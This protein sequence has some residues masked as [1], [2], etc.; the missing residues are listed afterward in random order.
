MVILYSLWRVWRVFIFFNIWAQYIL[1]WIDW[2]HSMRRRHKQRKSR[3]GGMK[4]SRT[5]RERLIER[6]RQNP[7]ESIDL[8]TVNEL[9]KE[10]VVRV[11]STDTTYSFVFEVTPKVVPLMD[12]RKLSREHA[13]DTESNDDMGVSVTKLCAKISFIR[14]TP[15]NKVLDIEYLDLRCVSPEE[16]QTEIV[17]QKKIHDL[18]A[19]RNSNAFVADVIANAIVT[20]GQFIDILNTWVKTPSLNTIRQMIER[21]TDVSVG[22]FLM[23]L[24]PTAKYTTIGHLPESPYKVRAVTELAAQF[25][26]VASEQIALYDGHSHNALAVYRIGFFRSIGISIKVLSP[27]EPDVR[28]IDFGKS[29]RLNV[30]TKQNLCSRFR[31]LCDHIN[32]GVN[33][34]SDIA[35]VCHFFGCT[36]KTLLT[37]F[38]TELQFPNFMCTVPAGV[39][40]VEPNVNN[41]HRALMMLAFIDFMMHNYFRCQMSFIIQYMYRMSHPGFE[42]EFS[43]F[44]R[45]FSLDDVPESNEL[46]NVVAHIKKFATCACVPP[47][48]PSLLR[49]DIASAAAMQ[50]HPTKSISQEPPS[51]CKRRKCSMLGGTRKRSRRKLN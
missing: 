34:W 49:Y 20:T 24:I 41:V 3:T 11:I 47:M 25:L 22:I 2:Y 43:N 29:L 6:M 21:L 7:N 42:L 18:L 33:T 30:E 26:V 1:C 14:K 45:T 48:K 32:E 15:G 40:T 12:T 37:K 50:P 19:C 27:I 38:E 23:E 46:A 9:L 13:I 16:F 5:M 31:S 36:E 51:S 28:M 44:L 8:V 10:S 35:T 17:V 4:F 39:P